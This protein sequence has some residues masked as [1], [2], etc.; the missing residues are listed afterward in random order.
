MN[1]KKEI[2]VTGIELSPGDPEA[3]KGNGKHDGIE[4]CCDEC[5]FFLKCFPE[6][7]EGG[8]AWQTK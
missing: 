1:E 6:W 2:D 3:C 5:D 7:E 8:S 4:C